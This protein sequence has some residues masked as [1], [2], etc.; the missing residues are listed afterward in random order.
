[1]RP[2]KFEIIECPHCGYQYLPSE[3]FVPKHFFGKPYGIERSYNGNIM[4]YEGTSIDLFESYQCDNCDKSFRITTKLS[5]S[6]SVE[7]ST[8]FN[9][10]YVSPLSKDSLF[11]EDV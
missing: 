11:S 8:T 7:E 6:T 2:R 9:E 10:E 4:E 5:F 3:I 1:M